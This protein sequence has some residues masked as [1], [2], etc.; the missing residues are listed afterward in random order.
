MEALFQQSGYD[1]ATG[2]VRTGGQFNLGPSMSDIATAQK[3]TGEEPLQAGEREKLEISAQNAL[4]LEVVKAG[5]KNREE[6]QKKLESAQRVT[7]DIS[8]IVDIFDQ[9]PTGPVTGRMA[10]GLAAISG[11]REKFAQ[12]ETMSASLV[13]SLGEY[14]TG[15]GGRSLSENEQKTLRNIFGFDKS[16]TA[17][18]FM[19]KLQAAIQLI[20]NRLPEGAVKLPPARQF[21]QMVR[22][23][24]SAGASGRPSAQDATSAQS[25]G[26][27]GYDTERSVFVNAQG[28]PV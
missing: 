22:Q 4:E 14:I 25:R 1:P 6:L 16:M 5:A 10:G 17:N 8:S 13:F 7:S 28:E 27:V 3:I 20:N 12:L 19:G 18:K 11:G 21:L 24:R 2:Q 26:A 9:I 15:Q 23:Q